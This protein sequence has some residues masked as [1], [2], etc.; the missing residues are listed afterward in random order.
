MPKLRQLRRSA[1]KRTNGVSRLADADH[2]QQTLF[3]E[4]KNPEQVA[5][6]KRRNQRE[7]E[8]L[9][10]QTQEYAERAEDIEA[11]KMAAEPP[12]V[13]CKCNSVPE[14][15]L[16]CEY[17]KRWWHWECHPDQAKL[18]MPA[19]EDAQLPWFDCLECKVL[20][21]KNRAVVYK[22]FCSISVPV[23]P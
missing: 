6:R 2:K 7:N 15:Q 20:Y 5:R 4:L 14:H 12:C 16:Q 13:R 10:K 22:Q 3:P 23:Q 1:R 8:K 11:A 9:D 17:C 18:G 19:D 21:V